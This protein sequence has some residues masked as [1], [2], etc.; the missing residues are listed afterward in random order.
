MS[1]NLGEMPRPSDRRREPAQKRIG[2]P[3]T[4]RQQQV[5][6]LHDQGL[7]PT[8][9]ARRLDIRRTSDVS[10]TLTDALAKVGRSE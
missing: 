5:L 6:A 1:N 10:A 8:A 7:L 3:L 4:A 9:I 2:K